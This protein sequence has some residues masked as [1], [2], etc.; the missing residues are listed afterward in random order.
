MTI[1]SS[2][3]LSFSEIA[4]EFGGAKPFSLSQFYRGGGRVPNVGANNNIPTSGVVRFSQYYSSSSYVSGNQAFASSGYLV[5]PSGVSV[6][7]V[8]GCGGGG[9]G[10]GLIDTG[11]SSDYGASGGGSSGLMLN[12]YAWAVSPGQTLQINIGAGGGPFAVGGNTTIVNL[13]TGATLTIPGGNPGQDV[14]IT[15]NWA[16]APGICPAWGAPYYGN[17]GLPATLVN[18]HTG[19][20]GG[21]GLYGGGGGIGI[22]AAS[23]YGTSIPGGNGTQVGA[24]GG[25]G[26]STNANNGG[27]SVGGYGA[28][29]YAYLNW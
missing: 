15:K 22:V 16:G 28:A 26:A 17:N 18:G 5:V 10:G 7:Y 19:G 11:N 1:K 12:S 14:T 2:G 23:T 20:N 13:S 25:S 9:G 3:Q 21:A 24:G 8:T 29:G 6:I 27:S 4:A